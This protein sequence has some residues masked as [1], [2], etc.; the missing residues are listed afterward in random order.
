MKKIYAF[1]FIVVSFIFLLLPQNTFAAQGWETAYKRFYPNSNFTGLASGGGYD[2]KIFSGNDRAW[3]STDMYVADFPITTDR[4]D[5]L[6][7]QGYIDSAYEGD[8]Q[9]TWTTTW[10]ENDGI[11][12]F[13]TQ[14]YGAQF[15]VAVRGSSDGSYSVNRG[16]W[17]KITPNSL[18]NSTRISF[19]M[20]CPIPHDMKRIYDFYLTMYYECSTQVNDMSCYSGGSNNFAV[21]FDPTMTIHFNTDGNNNDV[22]GAIEDTT[23]AIGETN[24]KLD[25]LNSSLNDSSTTGANSSAASFF[26]GFS[27][28]ANGHLTSI[29][30]APLTLFSAITSTTCTP[31]SIPLAFGRLNTATGG[32][33]PSKTI[34]LPCGTTLFWENSEFG[35]DIVSFRTFWNILIG[36]PLIYACLVLLMKSFNNALDPLND[37]VVYLEV[38]ANRDMKKKVGDNSGQ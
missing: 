7:V 3:T 38:S 10:Y 19:S 2:Y 8:L 13:R 23:D 16:S 9:P 32:S 24:D 33:V 26:N 36:A 20:E 34:S 21:A 4:Y 37:Q 30:T 31:V 18:G 6:F 1:S 17:C 25:D 28:D 35:N 12:I 29:V 15:K 27:T 5:T 11:Y 22:V 14:Y